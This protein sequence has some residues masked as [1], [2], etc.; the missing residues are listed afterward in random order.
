MQLIVFIAIITV[1]NNSPQ[2]AL[3]TGKRLYNIERPRLYIIV[4][5][6]GAADQPIT[7]AK[8]DCIAKI[9]MLT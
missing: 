6:I 5:R 3:S 8:F 2:I 7:Y 1:K 9:H 4:N